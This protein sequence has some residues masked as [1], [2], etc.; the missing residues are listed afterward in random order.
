MKERAKDCSVQHTVAERWVWRT[1]QVPYRR[2]KTWPAAGRSRERNPRRQLRQCCLL[3][4]S[5]RFHPYQK[6]DGNCLQW[7][8]NVIS[9]EMK[10]TDWWCFWIPV[11]GSEGLK[12][13]VRCGRQ[14]LPTARAAPSKAVLWVKGVFVLRPVF[15]FFV[16]LSLWDH[17]FLALSDNQDPYALFLL[18]R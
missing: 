3:V 1:Q 15:E 8:L 13:W 18:S 4:E 10:P 6:E 17:H 16:F 2:R 12:S 11:R 7:S 5:L 9:A 14:G